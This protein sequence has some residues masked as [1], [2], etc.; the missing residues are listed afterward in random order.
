[1]VIGYIFLLIALLCGS[2]KGYCGKKSSGTIVYSSDALLVNTLRMTLCILIGFII[3]AVSGKI[4][5]LLVS[6]TVLGIAALSGIATSGF[7]V[8]WL[9]S[10]RTGA[11]MMIDVCLMIGI[12]IPMVLCDILYG[13]HITVW[14][15]IGIA[16]LIIAGYIMCSYNAKL[17][18]KMKPSGIFLLILCAVSN[19]LTD[20]SQKLFVK[21][22][23]GVDIAVFG[24]Y[25]YVFSALSLAILFPIFRGIDQK[26]AKLPNSPKIQKPFDV[27]KPIA[28]YVVIM[29][30]CL[31]LN[32]YFKTAAAV[33]LT[34]TQIYPISQGGALMLATLMAHFFFKERINLRAVIGIVLCLGAL[35]IINLT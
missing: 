22:D 28:I 26:T 12:I 1:M 30:V 11:F 9:L 19:G 21:A 13:E 6:P 17:K 35:L 18:G 2:T 15:W 14:Q 5:Q 24:F 20:F 7:V 29:A 27:V 23:S 8:S 10:V 31:F 25:T 33:Y 32:S 4:P 34:A 3:I 16:L